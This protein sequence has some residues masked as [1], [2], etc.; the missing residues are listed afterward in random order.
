M[1][2]TNNL[3]NFLTDVATAI[4]TKKGTSDL[5]KASEFD[6][7]IESITMGD[8][9]LGKKEITKNGIYKAS[10]DN[11]GGY[12]EVDV[13]VPKSYKW[14]RP[15]D[16]Y[17]LPKILSE[18]EPIEY[19]EKTYYPKIAL[20]L[21]NNHTSEL[22]IPITSILYSSYSYNYVIKTNNNDIST[23]TKI[24]NTIS[25]ND[26]TWYLICYVE[27]SINNYT[28]RFNAT[29]KDLPVLEV[30][31]GSGT[32]SSPTLGAS[33]TGTINTTI[34]NFETLDTTVL[35]YLNTAH[36]FSNLL[37]LE[38]LKLSIDTISNTANLS[39]SSQSFIDIEFPNLT[40]FVRQTLTA[41][42]TLRRIDLPNC[43]SITSSLMNNYGLVELNIPKLK[44]INNTSFLQGTRSIEKLSLLSVE[45]GAP[46]LTQSYNLKEV[47]LPNNFKISGWSFAYCYKLTK[48]TL[49]DILNKLADVTEDTSTTYSITFGSINLSKLTEDEIAIGTNKG[50]VIS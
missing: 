48:S 5:I 47:E 4:R 42:Y 16:W 32:W 24:T 23:T 43:T 49:L 36:A 27:E 9:I 46:I 31:L 39:I 25:E 22:T 18:A 2:R 37:S 30:I 28:F 19:E 14:Q 6:S 41:Q 1:A 33:S 44:E 11:L 29:L 17:D 34:I 50:W 40:N 21:F 10:N 38:H 15:S 13:N 3:N 45:I 35:Q 7:E 26:K 20:Q 12:S 8:I